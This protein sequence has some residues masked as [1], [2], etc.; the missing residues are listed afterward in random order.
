MGGSFFIGLSGLTANSSAIDNVGNNL[1]NTNTVGFKSNNLF[2]E[3]LRALGDTSNG[4]NGGQGVAVNS[5]QQ[6]FSQGNIQ[7][8]QVSTDLAIRG[9]GFFIV[10]DGVNAQ[11]FT[12]AGNF[13]VNEEGKMV[14]ADGS[15]LV[16][17]FPLDQNG[18]VDANAKPA[19]IDLSP[20]RLIGANATTQIRVKTNLNS[21]TLVGDS[22]STST[23]VFDSLGSS[24]TLTLGFTRTAGGWDYS[25]GIPAANL[26][27]ST[28]DPEIIQT[29]SLQFDG[30]GRLISPTGDVTG[31]S[32][33]GLANGADDL[34]FDWDLFDVNGES[35]LTQ[36]TLPSATSE[37][38]QN[39]NGAGNLTN[40][41]VLD[42][43]T[44]EGLF[45]NGDSRPIGQ[46]A[47][48]S[49]T[50]PQGL[51]RIGN[52]LFSATSE[53]GETT[54]GQPLTGGRGRIEGSS[55]EMSNVDIAEEFIKL[56]LFQRGYQANARMIT[57]ADQITLET[58]QLKQ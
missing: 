40:M 46:I 20:G 4:T 3:E 54:I 38:F 19:P 28:S 39:G 11:F 47:L 30:T 45:S 1:A 8:T 23:Q 44:I 49:V 6:V 29:G 34:T 48:A 17:G 50:N 22:F 35:F 7:Q 43:G 18:Q 14:T 36:F 42:D 26:A 10:G 37:T 41:I 58:I 56:I 15:L 57:T 32:I 52:N 53:S 5:T 9:N 25:I 24:H 51:V 2:L 33:T 21:D 31:I 16:L 13:R 12:R 55:L 27:T